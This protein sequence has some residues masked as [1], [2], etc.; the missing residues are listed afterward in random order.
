MEVN[1]PCLSFYPRASALKSASSA[2]H[3]SG[4]GQRCD[5]ER[6]RVQHLVV[7]QVC[8]VEP[9]RRRWVTGTAVGRFDQPTYPTFH[10][11][12]GSCERLDRQRRLLDRGRRPG[13]AA[14]A[15]VGVLV[16]PQPALCPLQRRRP[17]RA[18]P[19]ADLE[20]PTRTV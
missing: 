7:P 12:A 10:I 4:G 15:A 18:P 5:R 8:E 9:D 1:T 13:P 2:C 16:R 3:S 19:A 6:D 20:Y 14:P 17:R 11:L